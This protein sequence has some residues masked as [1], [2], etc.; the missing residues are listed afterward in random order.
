MGVSP[1]KNSQANP[2]NVPKISDTPP[3]LTV[4]LDHGALDVWPEIM[5]SKE[6]SDFIPQKRI[7]K[8]FTLVKKENTRMNDSL[9]STMNEM[10]AKASIQSKK[11][12]NIPKRRASVHD[13]ELPLALSLP[14]NQSDLNRLR[15]K[16]SN[17]AVQR[18]KQRQ[19]SR[20]ANLSS[21]RR[22]YT[23]ASSGILKISPEEQDRFLRQYYHQ[24]VLLKRT[25]RSI[26]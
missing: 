11:L 9:A 3:R 25:T 19:L 4:T 21:G 16:R 17:D 6:S 14:R 13:E 20:S 5:E 8:P 2:E 24:L 23:E 1:S 12:E 7:S 15:M 22:A 10:L 18:W 26:C